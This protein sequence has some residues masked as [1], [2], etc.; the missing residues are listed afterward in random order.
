MLEFKSLVLNILDKYFSRKF[1][2]SEFTDFL[3]PLL[4]VQLSSWYVISWFRKESSYSRKH[5]VHN[6]IEN[7]ETLVGFSGMFLTIFLEFYILPSFFPYLSENLINGFQNPHLGSLAI[8]L[9]MK[10]RTWFS[11]SLWNA[12]VQL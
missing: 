6:C 8:F 3:S 11:M 7:G 2:C 5:F 1:H 10:M 9:W 12:S 4:N